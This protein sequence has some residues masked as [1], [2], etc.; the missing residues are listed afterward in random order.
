MQ[1]NAEK[2]DLYMSDP[3]MPAVNRQEILCGKISKQDAEKFLTELE[4]T[5]IPPES[6]CFG[7]VSAHIN[8]KTERFVMVSELEHYYKSCKYNRSHGQ[9]VVSFDRVRCK[10]DFCLDNIKTGKCVDDFI[11]T[12][13]G[14]KLFKKRYS[15]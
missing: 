11:R 1:K 12:V 6:S 8:S 3:S 15:K 5:D 10:C 14:K 2:Y 13:I 4:K 7:C 9:L